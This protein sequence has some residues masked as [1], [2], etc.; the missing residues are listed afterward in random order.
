MAAPLATLNTAN[1]IAYLS[2]LFNWEMSDGKFT[3]ALDKTVS[4]SIISKSQ[5]PIEQFIQGEINT[6][7]L[8][9]NGA[10]NGGDPNK[11]LF[12]TALSTTALRE[13][14]TRKH[15]RFR[16][17]FANY[18]QLVS[19][20]VGG[21]VIKF[22]LCFTGTMYQTAYH[23][24]IQVIFNEKTSALGI[25][26]HPFYGKIQRVLPISL[27]NAYKADS[28]NTILCDVTFLTSDI[29]HLYGNIQTSLLS[30]ISKW[31]IGLENAFNSLGATAAAAKAL[32]GGFRNKI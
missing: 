11:F 21:Q 1:Q 15:A 7:E 4:F 3:N 29:T 13:E 8:L 32:G 30:T 14:I 31:F 5:I 27:G 25:L 23:N 12:N 10:F 16:V 9:T 19:Q 28:L 6:F 2:G 22:D 18:D 20:G 26:D 24:F 17:P